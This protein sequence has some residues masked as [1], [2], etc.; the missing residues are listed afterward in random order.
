MKGNEKTHPFRDAAWIL[1]NKSIQILLLLVALYSLGLFT[2]HRRPSSL[3]QAFDTDSIEETP[4]LGQ[5]VIVSDAGTI[6]ANDATKYFVIH[7]GPQKTAST[8][9][10]QVSAKLEDS[11]LKDDN[12][13][14]FGKGKKK[15]GALYGRL[16]DMGCRNLV[17]EARLSKAPLPECWNDFVDTLKA[18]SDRNILV[19]SEDLHV[20]SSGGQ[21]E[22]WAALK[23]AAEAVG[24]KVILVVAYRRFYEWLPSSYYQMNSGGASGYTR[25][26]GDGGKRIEPIYPTMMSSEY[27]NRSRTKR[28]WHY[29]IP[30]FLNA[31]PEFM[32]TRILNMHH[33]NHTR[34]TQTKF[35]C[36]VLPNAFQT[37][38]HSLDLEREKSREKFH[39]ASA[40]LCY[41]MLALAAAEAGLID[42]SVYKRVDVRKAA[43]EYNTLKLN[44]TDTDFPLICPPKHHLKSIL[45]AS[46]QWEKEIMP[47]M[48]DESGHRR[49]FWDLVDKKK[50]CAIDEQATL[51]LDEWKSFFQS[52]TN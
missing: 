6:E 52:Y 4:N 16:R 32:E 7:V 45:N 2:S 14:Y 26:P 19:S 3:E 46:L 34:T 25:W 29:Y 15:R 44:R 40:P 39:R 1:K 12:Y 38:Q 18:V 50:F 31:I 11:F 13:Y 21:R 43:K 33:G 9:I 24:L 10:Q 8:H 49:G 41:D 48:D 37:C 35:F 30:S 42:T 22:W 20:A 47:T 36:D 17:H 5:S 28:L 27:V 51:K 23:E